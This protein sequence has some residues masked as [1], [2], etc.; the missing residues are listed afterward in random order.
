MIGKFTLL[1][2]TLFIY[3]NILKIKIKSKSIKLGQLN[4]TIF[5]RKYVPSAVIIMIIIIV[6]TQNIMAQG[7]NTDEYANKTLLSAIV[8]SQEESWS[9]LIEETGPAVQAPKVSNYL[10]DQ[11]SLQEI[12][13]KTPFEEKDDMETNPESGSLVI[14]NPSDAEQLEESGQIRR[15]EPIEY[16]VQ[17]GDVLGKIAEKFGVS[18]NTILWENNLTWSSVIKPGQ[19][20][21]IL[22]DSGISHKVKSG[23]TILAI[24]KEYQTDA[25]KIIDANKLADAS[26]ISIGEELFIPNGVK[27]T[28]V[29]TSYKP[30]VSAYSDENYAPAADVDTG[31]KLLWPV[32]SKRITQYYHLGHLAIDIG[33]KIGDPIYAAESGKVEV[34]GWNNG[35]YGNYVII[36]HGNGLKTLYGH[37][38]KLLVKAGD[39]VSRGQTIALIGSTGRSTGPHLH[40]EVRLN[41]SKQNPLNYV[42]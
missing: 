36:N 13:I 41:N 40:F 30:R 19:K 9:E 1:P 12:V 23:D 27:P 22:Q 26:D 37:A 24:A 31:T 6:S 7:Y 15:S 33:D 32:L 11:G 3:K 4:Y 16:T 17:P 38:S 39:S 34:A 18:T 10:E 14:I 2:T 20:L 25:Q 21:T 29:V 5:L 35:G 8:P 28:P 42:K